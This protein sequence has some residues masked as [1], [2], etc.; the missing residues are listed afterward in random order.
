MTGPETFTIEPSGP[1]SLEEAAMFGFGQW[2]DTRFDGTMRLAFCVDGYDAQVGVAITQDARGTVFGTVAGMTGDPSATSVRAQV[3][4]VLSLDHDAIGYVAVGD[5]DPVIGRLLAAAPGLRPPLFYSPYEAA[6]WAILSARRPSQTAEAW[7][8]KLSGALGAGFDVA[9]SM[10]WSVPLPARIEAAGADAVEAATGMDATRA[11]R[12]VAV[13]QAAID[14]R[15]DAGALTTADVDS[16]RATLR[17]IPGIGPFYADL[18][19]IRGTGITDLLP[20]NEPRML[21]L[22]GEL[23]RLGGPAT[24]AQADAIAETWSPWRTWVAVL[25]RAAGPRVLGQSPPSRATRASAS[26]T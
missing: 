19:L 25:V 6:L 26:R 1:F 5:R 11:Q 8:R 7:R 4:R 22:I 3:A 2:H 17:T 24:G 20:T 18:V 15:L 23:Y 21:A 9:G 10:M 14:G 16:A 13:A 12:I